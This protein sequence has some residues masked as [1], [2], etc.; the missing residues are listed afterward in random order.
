MP[1]LPCCASI[2]TSLTLGVST[3]TS[4][5]ARLAHGDRGDRVEALSSNASNLRCNPCCRLRRSLLLWSNSRTRRAAGRGHARTSP[6]TPRP[7]PFASTVTC[8]KMTIRPGTRPRPCCCVDSHFAAGTTLQGAR[9]CPMCALRPA[10]RCAERRAARVTPASSHAVG[11]DPEQP[12]ESHI[13]GAM[14]GLCLRFLVDRSG[15]S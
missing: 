2:T 14:L 6:Q 3:D 15:P 4:S 13:I 10:R 1:S 5:C 11:A 9:V 12:D 8:G 7:P